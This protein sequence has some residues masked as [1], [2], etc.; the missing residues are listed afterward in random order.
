MPS[1]GFDPLK[2]HELR[3]SEAHHQAAQSFLSTIVIGTWSELKR[4][5]DF[6]ADTLGVQ[7][8]IISTSQE[9]VDTRL[10]LYEKLAELYYLQ[11]N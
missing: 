6:L 7:E 1:N 8:L 3:F 10:K 5:L 9:G 4:K 11:R 2:A